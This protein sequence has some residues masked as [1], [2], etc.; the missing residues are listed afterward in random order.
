MAIGLV[1][2]R[3]VEER[4]AIHL[5]RDL[6]DR[7]DVTKK[8]APAAAVSR[9]RDVRGT[10]PRGKGIDDLHDAP[11]ATPLAPGRPGQTWGLDAGQW[12]SIAPA[13]AG[14]VGCYV[15]WKRRIPARWNTVPNVS[16]AAR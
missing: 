10:H 3:G 12:L 2:I 7:I 14:L 4:D 11:I 6:R 1:A 16:G 8:E 9:E 13:L 15:S 5:R